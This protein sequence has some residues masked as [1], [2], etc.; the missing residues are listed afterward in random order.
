MIIIIIIILVLFCLYNMLVSHTIMQ[1]NYIIWG[2][3]KQIQ[4]I[5]FNA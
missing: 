3:V 5:L 2:H 4:T 1:L